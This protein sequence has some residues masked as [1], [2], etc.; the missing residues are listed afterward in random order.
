MKD[1]IFPIT[2]KNDPKGLKEAES[3]LERLGKGV[4]GLAKIGAAAAAATAA[5]G[6]AW[7][8]SSAKQ[9]MEIEKLNAQTNAAIA[10]TGS[11]AGK[12]IEQINK[13]NASLEKLTGIEAEV[14]QQGQNM[15]LTFTNIKGD[16]FDDATEAALN[17]SVALGKDMA[18]SAMLVGKA[19]ND[20]IAGLSA[21]SRAGIQF[22]D[23]QKETIKSLV[24]MGDTAGA[25]TIIL[26]ELEKQFG[27]SA[28]AFGETTAGMIAKFQNE[29]G[30]LGESIA[31]G[32]MPAVDAMLPQ[33]IAFVDEMQASPDFKAFVD[34]L[35]G[36]FNDMLPKLIPVMEN[37]GNLLLILLPGLN[38]LLDA[39]GSALGIISLTMPSVNEGG[40]EMFTVWGKVADVLREIESALSI[41]DGF[42][43][44]IK[45]SGVGMGE[46]I[47]SVFAGLTRSIS[48][49]VRLFENL[50][51]LVQ[52]INRTSIKPSG[53]TYNRDGSINRDG[54]VLTPFAK[55]GIVTG[56]TPALVGEAGPEAI[57][58]LDRFDDVVG[59][60]GGGGIVINVNA[61]MG[62][63][64]AAVG[65]QIVNAIRR[66]ERTSGAVFAR[67]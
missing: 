53:L 46:I 13:L 58:P 12:S 34:G 3:G 1:I 40:E 21:L 47:V 44:D 48:P 15:L 11:A 9:L 43:N 8:V 45:I 62:T 7:V 61:G 20:P 35:A 51:N 39:M 22:T 27:G 31:A 56:P 37:F 60:R 6:V 17:L 16:Q 36:S 10:S 66:Y 23:S 59:K 54:N 49:L 28:E 41:A 38:P 14:I 18:S 2:Y 57:I 26:A 50:W 29:L 42:L 55:G 5:V 33:L 25:Q 67:A 24:E 30:E 65:E 64:G 19:L 32:L 4:V 63:D 52:L